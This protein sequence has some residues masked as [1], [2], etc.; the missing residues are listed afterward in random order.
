MSNTVEQRPWGSFEILAEGQGYKVKK[1]TVNPGQRLSLQS[2]KHRKEIWTIY[3]GAGR[4]DSGG[5]GIQHLYEG[6][7]MNIAKNQKHRIWNA[8]DWDLVIIE[9]Q[10]GDYLGEDDIIRYEDDYGRVEAK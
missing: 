10:V 2:H 1:I 3:K 7:T 4:Y 8:L 5:K 6:S 9:V